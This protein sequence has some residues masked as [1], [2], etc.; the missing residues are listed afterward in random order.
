MLPLIPAC[1][2]LKYSIFITEYTYTKRDFM[3]QFTP[4]PIALIWKKP[5]LLTQSRFKK[6]QMYCKLS[7]RIIN[8]SHFLFCFLNRSLNN[9][10]CPVQSDATHERPVM[11]APSISFRPKKPSTNSIRTGFQEASANHV[12]ED[13]RG[14]FCS[15]CEQDRINSEMLP[16]AALF[17]WEVKTISPCILGTDRQNKIYVKPQ[18]ILNRQ[19]V[20]LRKDHW[21]CFQ[22]AVSYDFSFCFTTTAVW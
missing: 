6:L 17:V 20:T 11:S 19:G 22:G 7:Q 14:M 15:H 16:S 1:K 13:H 8:L 10:A 12:K 21:R 18:S 9:S 4:F 5:L 3:S 2:P